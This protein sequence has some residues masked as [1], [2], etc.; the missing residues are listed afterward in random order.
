[1]LDQGV[2][3][4]DARTRS[5]VAADVIYQVRSTGIGVRGEL[6]PMVL[7]ARGE[8]WDSRVAPPWTRVAWRKLDPGTIDF[9]LRASDAELSALVG[10][11]TRT[12][13]LRARASA[14]TSL[15]SLSRDGGD[16]VR[17]ATVDPSVLVELRS[18]RS[19]VSLAGA[20]RHQRERDP[21]LI[22]P[23]L[24]TDLRPTRVGT[25]ALSAQHRPAERAFMRLDGWF[26]RSVHLAAWA[27]GSSSHQRDGE[28]RAVGVDALVGAAYGPVNG[29]LS[30]SL[31]WGER[32]AWPAA[33]SRHATSVPDLLSEG[34]GTCG[35]SESGDEG[36]LTL[37][38]DGWSGRQVE[39]LIAKI[40]YRF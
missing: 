33:A 15:W 3:R 13:R 22:H 20:V 21:L 24:T 10:A 17:T 29:A 32:A 25:V 30:G 39:S 35:N 11:W 9:D 12:G 5:T 1:M 18:A 37:F 8:A 28:G 31:A 7:T 2:S 26:R 6:A 19:I 16:P 27:P 36:P 38:D 14:R 23:D 34:S 4:R 40:R